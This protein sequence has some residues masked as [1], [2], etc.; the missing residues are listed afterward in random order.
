MTDNELVIKA[1]KVARSISKKYKHRTIT[2]QYK[3]A[4]HT[5]ATVKTI[6]AWRRTIRDGGELRLWTIY[7]VALENFIREN[8]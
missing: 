1:L 3:L 4:M 6:S 2:G 7:R 5:G 8:Q